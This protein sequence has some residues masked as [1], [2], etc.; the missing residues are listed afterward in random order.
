M[1]KRKVLCIAI[2]RD[3]ESDFKELFSKKPL[4][5]IDQAENM[6]YLD[7]YEQ[8]DKLLSP[9]KMDLLRYLMEEQ[10]PE[11][12]RSITQIAKALHRHQEAISRD[13]ASLKNLG[14][15][16]LKKTKQTVYVLPAYAK[17]NIQI[18]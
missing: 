8:L 18:C 9:K 4:S 15:V 12:P 16:L 11:K 6:L 1:K 17:V 10:T 3:M 2:G 5:E 13:I 7:S 14:M